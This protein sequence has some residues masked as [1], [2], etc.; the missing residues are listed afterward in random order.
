M[1]I[2]K[3]QTP[4]LTFKVPSFQTHY[5]AFCCLP[6]QAPKCDDRRHAGAIEKEDGSETLQAERVPE[7]APVEW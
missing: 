2:T 1:E 3:K 4:V 6:K 7:V 5:I